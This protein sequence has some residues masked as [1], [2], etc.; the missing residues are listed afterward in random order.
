MATRSSS[1][2]TA[3]GLRQNREGQY[4]L[5]ALVDDLTYTQVAAG[6]RYRALLMRRGRAVPASGADGDRAARLRSEG[7][8][9]ASDQSRP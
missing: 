7:T 5:Q 2:A 6:S 3:S 8:A 1:G 4:D 9:A